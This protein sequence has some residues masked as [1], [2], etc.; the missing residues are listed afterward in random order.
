[1][2]DARR[3]LVDL[4]RARREDELVQRCR[5]TYRA[6][7]LT[8]LSI[9]LAVL[10]TAFLPVVW[11]ANDH[12]PSIWVGFSVVLAGALGAAVAGTI[13]ARDRL[14]LQSD[15]RRFRH[16]IVAQL[17][18]G[19]ASAIVVYAILRAFPIT[20]DNVELNL[21][22]LAEKLSVAFVAGFS[23]PFFIGTIE[24]VNKLIDKTTPTTSKA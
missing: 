13:K 11:L 21:N 3:K 15:L 1:M 5:G 24:R 6:R 12:R 17:L 2:E 4:Y 22:T 23:E 20:I 10:L 9:V 7:A 19:G 14:I 16:D 8:T 18:I